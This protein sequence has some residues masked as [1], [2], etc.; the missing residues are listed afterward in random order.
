MR[1]TVALVVG[2]IV[3]YYCA[4]PMSV[5]SLFLIPIFVL[6]GGIVFALVEQA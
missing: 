1:V 5:S 2:V 3:G 4:I 6:L